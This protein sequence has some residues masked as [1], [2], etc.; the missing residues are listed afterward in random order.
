VFGRAG[1]SADEE[2]AANRR[3]RS[4]GLA[5]HV[6]RR[7]RKKEVKQHGEKDDIH[8]IPSGA[9]ADVCLE[10]TGRVSRKNSISKGK[11]HSCETSRSRLKNRRIKT[12]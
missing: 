3:E 7:T 6:A 12:R 11:C 5:R 10:V 9:A 2:G 8:S 1:P 4:R